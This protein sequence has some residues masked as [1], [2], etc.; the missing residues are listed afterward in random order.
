MEIGIL[1]FIIFIGMLSG[2]ITGMI[3][4][5]H[6]NL[7]SGLIISNLILLQEVF[8]QKYLIVFIIVMGVTHTF[9]DFIPSILFSVPSS[10]TA[11]SLLPAQKLTAEG[12]AYKAIYISSIGSLFGMFFAIIL[13]P[14]FYLFL[15]KTYLTIKVAIPYFLCFVIL[16]LV[17]TEKNN[18]LKFFAI[19]V[20]LFS[21]GLGFLILNTSMINYPLLILFTGIFGISTLI[22]S[23]NSEQ[24]KFPKQKFEFEFIRGKDF[25]KS[26]FVGGISSAVCSITPGIGNAQA[27]TIST[28]FVKK[29]TSELFIVITSAI[30]T[31]NFILSFLTFYLISKTRNGAVFAI[32]QITAEITIEEL[33]FYFIIIF[34]VSICGFLITLFLG[35][36]SIKFIEKVN[37]KMFNF[38]IILFLFIMIFYMNGIYGLLFLI[39]CTSLGLFAILIGVKRVHLM[40]SLLIPVIFNIM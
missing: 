7:I 21:S 6:I 15:E 39:L 4:G 31:I 13:V 30:N 17:L 25:Y 38:F 18:N 12:D 27:A 3:P 34:I 36:L 9:V 24:N 22:Q 1:L 23:L 33:I 28:L 14:F 5:I 26:I 37:F 16:F 2:I 8:L 35:K 19:I 32:S 20:V 29:I 11:L 10:D 40:S